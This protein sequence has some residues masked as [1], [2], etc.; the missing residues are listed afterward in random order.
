LGQKLAQYRAGKR[1]SKLTR[2]YAGKYILKIM[3]SEPEDLA[4]YSSILQLIAGLTSMCHKTD[5]AVLGMCG[6]RSK[7]TQAQD[8]FASNLSMICKLRTLFIM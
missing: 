5:S 2:I 4:R 6:C 8:G 7:V 3:R 1:W